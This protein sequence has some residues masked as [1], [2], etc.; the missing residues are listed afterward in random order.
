MQMPQTH[1]MKFNLLLRQILRCS[2]LLSLFAVLLQTETTE[3]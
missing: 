2:F 1:I 3:L